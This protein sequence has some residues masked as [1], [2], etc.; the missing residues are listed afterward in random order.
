MLVNFAKENIL[1]WEFTEHRPTTFVTTFE[2]AIEKPE[3]CDF[4]NSVSVLR[5]PL[6]IHISTKG[7]ETCDPAAEIKPHP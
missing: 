6:E 7:L 1:T 3:R 4:S 2:Y 5:P